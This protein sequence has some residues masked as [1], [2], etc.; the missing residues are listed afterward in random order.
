MGI[1]SVEVSLSQ[2][3]PK[4]KE[5]EREKEEEENPEGIVTLSDSDEFE[6]F[7]QPLSP[8]NTSVDIDFQQ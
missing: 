6:M 7:N 5:E 3:V 8:E 1:P 2:P 4:E